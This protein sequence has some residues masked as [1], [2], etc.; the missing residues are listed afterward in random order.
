M[1]TLR[2]RLRGRYFPGILFS[3]RTNKWIAGIISWTMVGCTLVWSDPIDVFLPH[4]NFDDVDLSADP[5]GVPW[6]YQIGPF[7][8]ED[9]PGLEWGTVEAGGY[10]YATGGAHQVSLLNIGKQDYHVYQNL[11][12]TLQPY[13]EYVLTVALG[14]RDRW[15]AINTTNNLASIGLYAGG[16]PLSG[17]TELAAVTNNFFTLVPGSF[18]L[19]DVSISYTTG[20]SP[21][22]G[23]IY[24][25]LKNPS[26]PG[27]L[28]VGEANTF[29]GTPRAHFDNVR[30]TREPLASPPIS[31]II[32]P[33]PN[34]RARLSWP[35]SAGGFV[36]QHRDVHSEAWS[37]NGNNVLIEGVESVVYDTP[38][39]YRVYRL[40]RP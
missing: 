2:E 13:N 38:I 4:G 33:R 15:S 37:F 7:W 10:S 27:I 29:P 16:D 6:T 25:V 31:L 28:G 35:L 22:T 1:I 24:V 17:G 23:N 9:E 30:L 12:V 36:L 5:V 32:E 11:P 40:I 26:V 21:P 18:L 39:G 8:E 19:V 3:V 34:N 20:S 14:R